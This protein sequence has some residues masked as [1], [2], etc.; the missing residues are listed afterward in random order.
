MSTGDAL[1][2]AQLV[3]WTGQQLAPD[4]PQYNCVFTFEL[5]GPLDVDRFRASYAELVAECDNMRTVFRIHDGELVQ[6]VQ[7]TG[8]ADLPVRDWNGSREELEI[9]VTERGERVFDLSKNGTDAVL[10]QLAED[11]HLF[12][13]N[14]H[15]LIVDAWGVSVQYRRLAEL[16]VGRRSAG[17]APS[18]KLPSFQD[19]RQQDPTDKVSLPDYW[20]QENQPVPPRLFGRGNTTGVSRSPRLPVV[21]DAERMSALIALAER[22]DVRHW[23]REMTVYNILTSLLVAYV[24]RVSGQT[25]ITLGTPAANRSTPIE[26]RLPAQLIEML[27]LYGS[28]AKDD[29]LLTLLQRLRVSTNEFLKSARPGLVRSELSASFNVVLN[30][31]TAAFGPFTGDIDCH[32][33]WRSPGHADP[34][35]HL[36]LQAHDLDGSGRLTLEFDL[37]EAVFPE[38][39]RRDIPAQFLRLFDAL[40]REPEL[41][42]ADVDLLG[43]AATEGIL[44]GGLGQTTTPKKLTV[45]EQFREQARQQPTATA[46]AHG[47]QRLTYAELDEQSGRLAAFLQQRIKQPGHNVALFLPRSADLLV[48]ILGCWKAG[49][50]YLPLPTDLPEAR[51]E[52]ILRE[53]D[54]ALILSDQS[55]FKRVEG[56]RIPT[57]LLDTDRPAIDRH[58]P[59]AD[60][61]TG[62]SE[63]AYIMYTS[64]STGTPKGVEVGHASLANYIDFARGRYVKGPQPTF[65]LFTTIGFDLTVTSLFT[66]LTCGGQII[67]YPEPEPGTP[68][69]AV[70][71]VMDDDRCD[72]VKLTPSHLALLRGRDYRQARLRTLIV[73]G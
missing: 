9:A 67:V 19:Y 37:N 55:R 21:L 36:R 69:L 57:I 4:S 8:S 47:D 45:L 46:V 56:Y 32:T 73:G 38:T 31:I 71:R 24:Y 44:A 22:R 48:A 5:R 34:G 27:P 18:Q 68:D 62:A 39:V 49:H 2:P 12:F 15:H 59:L 11:H 3:L 17:E 61:P 35:H 41:A 1:T 16:Y 43:D 64:G 52:H 7:P 66:P 50:T 58:D 33:R 13:L 70:L 63:L 53:T 42:I 6:V 65:P 23:T 72:V 60:V 10:Y 28:V 25:E 54:C 51:L 29:T 30:Y 14:Q 20:Q 26:R 40:V